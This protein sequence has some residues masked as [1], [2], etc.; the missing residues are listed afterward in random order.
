MSAPDNAERDNMLWG[1]AVF[2]I[3]VLLFIGVVGVA[4]IYDAA[5]GS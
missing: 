2:G 3:F 4:L 1:W 5:L